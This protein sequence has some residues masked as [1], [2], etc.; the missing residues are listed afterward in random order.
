MSALQAQT[1]GRVLLKWYLPF[2]SCCAVRCSGGRKQET[3]RKKREEQ[4]QKEQLEKQ[5]AAMAKFEEEQVHRTLP[6]L[7]RLPFDKL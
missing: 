5:A 7:L 3:A 4:L 1:S 6:L 2:P